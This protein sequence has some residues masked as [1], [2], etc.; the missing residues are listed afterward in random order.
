MRLST[1]VGVVAVIAILAEAIILRQQVIGLGRPISSLLAQPSSGVAESRPHIIFL[2]RAGDCPGALEIIDRWNVVS[3]GRRAD[4]Q[5]ILIIGEREEV[6]ADEIIA[7]Y[8][9]HFPVRA[10]TERKVGHSLA[11]LGVAS[12]P[13]TL[14]FDERLVLR[15][16]LPGS[17]T[18][19][20]SFI[21][22]LSARKGP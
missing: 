3:R 14:L 5:G 12:L 18:P 19:A 11:L 10:L 21:E 9:F 7:S 20:D 13:V 15:T 8:G 6:P 16:I 22:T 17:E 4:V 1:A 2:F